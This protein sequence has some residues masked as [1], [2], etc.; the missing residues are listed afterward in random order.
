MAA[1]DSKHW[2][3]LAAGS[4][5]W[6]DYRHQADVCHAYQV[7]HRNGIPDKQIVVMMYDDIANNEQNPEK[8][9]IIRIPNGRNVYNY[10]RVMVPKDYTG[11][12]VSA[13]N[14]L[15][16]LRGDSSAGAKVIQ[17]G[18]NDTVFVYLSDH[19]G[20]GI[21]GFPSSTL[22]AHDLIETVTA[23]SQAGKFSKMVIYIE[24]CCSGS[25][26][27]KLNEL[28]ISNVYAV[29]SCKPD[30][31]SYGLYMDKKLNA[32]LSDVFTHCWLQ[33]TKTVRLN[34]TTFGD[35]FSY[36][37]EKVSEAARRAGVSQTPC[38]YGDMNIANVMLSELLGESPAPV[39]RAG[40]VPPTDFTVSDVIDTTEIPL[41]IKANR[42][43][44]EKDP[45][46]REIL[47]SQYDD[48]VRK[49]KT[50]DEAL[51][52][53]EM[54]LK[55]QQT[56]AEKHEV[57]RTYLLKD[58]AEHFKNNLFNWEKE[59]DV[60]THLHFQVLVNLCESGLKVESI[61]K[62]I[63][64]VANS[65]SLRSNHFP[66]TGAQGVLEI[67]DN[68]DRKGNAYADG[69]YAE[70]KTY[71]SASENKPGKRIRKSGAKYQAG[72]GRVGA[73][74]SVFAVEANCPNV[75]AEA[76]ANVLE[77][78]AMAAAELVSVS[79]VAGP[80]QLKLGLGLDTGVSLGPAKF[81]LKIL[82]TG[83]SFGSTM[84]ISLFGSEFK[85]KL[86]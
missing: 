26:V 69:L 43:A 85:L 65:P 76:M 48:L 11:E 34:T 24:S 27:E 18:K 55:G 70:K 16:V 61:N 44:N 80:V 67:I 17:S 37:K 49:R 14:F 35:Q 82:G 41:L 9:K 62:A 42:I 83:V 30:E 36:L 1:S 53:I 78:R 7:M 64:H 57:T 74:W 10:R 19:G 25:M 38:N 6:E 22:Y 72:V 50:M 28:N 73:A 63:T 5:G 8:G 23:M 52:K 2:V 4:K 31:N 3:L 84:G 46:T 86:F 54:R 20:P 47:E 56:L 51:K 39:T 77:G 45:K 58:V 71:A 66:V 13:E 60:V 21:F 15:A 59:P 32:C 81:E 40:S 29:S 12:N 79:A 68:F 75:S 33:H